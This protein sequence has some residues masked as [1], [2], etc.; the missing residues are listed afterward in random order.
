MNTVVEIELNGI[1]LSVHGNYQ[2]EEPEVTYYSDGSGY[3]GC[4]AS[5]E[6]ERITWSNKDEDEDVTD[7]LLAMYV[8]E[9]EEM[10]LDQLFQEFNEMDKYYS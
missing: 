3:P 10:C 6:V 8:E 2:P 7:I 9:I 5:F 1:K 4:P